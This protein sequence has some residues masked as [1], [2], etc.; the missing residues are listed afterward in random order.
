MSTDSTDRGSAG[1]VVHLDE[2][3]QAKHEAVVR[4]VGNLL[5][6]LGDGLQME[7]VGHGHWPFATGCRV[8]P[9][10]VAPDRSTRSGRTS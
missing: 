2:G 7:L 6:D 4:N 1:V 5:D 9:R 10:D 3:E 8:V